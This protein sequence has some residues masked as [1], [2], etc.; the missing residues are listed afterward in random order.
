MYARV[1]GARETRRCLCGV[2]RGAFRGVPSLVIPILNPRMRYEWE[3]SSIGSLYRSGNLRTRR[4]F[5]SFAW[6]GRSS[7]GSRA[8]RCAQRGRPCAGRN[9]PATLWFH[10]RTEPKFEPYADGYDGENISSGAEHFLAFIYCFS[11]ISQPNPDRSFSRVRL[12]PRRC[13]HTS[14][15]KS[16]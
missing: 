2:G 15:G 8:R 3:W 16:A 4:S 7:C 11:A 6:G 13:A 9:E 10:R 12:S 14:D 5:G 1:K